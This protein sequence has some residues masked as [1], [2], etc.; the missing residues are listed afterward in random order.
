MSMKPSKKVAL[1]L[2]VT[3]ILCIIGTVCWMFIPEDIGERSFGAFFGGIAWTVMILFIETIVLAII[4]RTHFMAVLPVLAP[5]FLISFSVL[6]Y[7]TYLSIEH[8][9]DNAPITITSNRARLVT[10]EQYTAD[11]LLIV[12]NGIPDLEKTYRA[13]YFRDTVVSTSVV[14]IWYSADHEKFLAVLAHT[15]IPDGKE[16]AEY[17]G[18]GQLYRVDY[19]VGKRDQEKN[20]KLGTPNGGD[21]LAD[22]ESTAQLKSEVEQYYYHNYSINGSSSKPEIWQDTFLFHFNE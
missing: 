13:Q 5:S 1:I 7:M 8:Y 20:W 15:F 6:V 2:G 9:L 18:A 21:W 19:I 12:N 17:N 3:I 10:D 14:D 22:F 11:S 4:Y 16:A